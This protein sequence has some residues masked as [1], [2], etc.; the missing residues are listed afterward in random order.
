METYSFLREMADSW[1]LLALF[2]I[3]IGI[4]VFLFRPG[5]RKI[6]DEAASAPFRNEDKPAADPE[7]DRT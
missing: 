6:H 1:G 4:A 5:H 2:L 7:E 3:F